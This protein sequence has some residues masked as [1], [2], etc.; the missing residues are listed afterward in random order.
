[1]PRY[2][3]A[4]AARAWLA[5]TRHILP[6]RRVI[7]IT[8]QQG[9]VRP[10]GRAA[11]EREGGP[12]ERDVVRQKVK[13]GSVEQAE[14]AAREL[15]ATL[16]RVRPEGIRYASTRVTDSSTFVALLEL[17]DGRVLGAMRV[18]QSKAGDSFTSVVHAIWEI[19]DGRIAKIDSFFDRVRTRAR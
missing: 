1:M 16:E 14:V 7:H 3:S 15:F 18:T 11:A 17:A 12:D 13:D 8:D 19:R 5:S 10:S 9:S 2:A 6:S 4:S